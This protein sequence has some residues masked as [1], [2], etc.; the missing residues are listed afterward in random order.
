VRGPY[1]ET[2]GCNAT[3]VYS[4]LVADGNGNAADQANHNRT[5]LRGFQKTE[6]DGMVTFNTLFPGHYY[7]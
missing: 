3:G 7:T 4:G 6:S 1:A 5:F 2:W